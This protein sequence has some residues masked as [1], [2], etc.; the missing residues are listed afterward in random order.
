MRRTAN[1]VLPMRHV[2]TGSADPD[3]IAQSLVAALGRQ[4]VEAGEEPAGYAISFEF[5][6]W[7]GDLDSDGPERQAVPADLA[8]FVLVHARVDTRPK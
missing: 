8:D 3:A 4:A 5:F 2:R 7:T 6:R 1:R